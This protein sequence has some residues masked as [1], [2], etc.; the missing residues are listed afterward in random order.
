[1][2]TSLLSLDFITASYT[3]PGLADLPV[4]FHDWLSSTSTQLRAGNWQFWSLRYIDPHHAWETFGPGGHIYLQHRW[5]CRLAWVHHQTWA[6]LARRFSLRERRDLC[7]REKKSKTL[8]GIRMLREQKN[9]NLRTDTFMAFLSYETSSVY[10]N[11]SYKSSLSGSRGCCFD[12]QF[13]GKIHKIF[14]ECRSYLNNFL[15]TAMQT[16]AHAMPLRRGRSCPF[17]ANI[18]DY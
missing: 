9:L 6:C 18:L 11:H 17:K 16:I 10:S 7:T 14:Q 15:L 8:A 12:P 2:Q 13:E 3:K 5:L 4:P 1:M